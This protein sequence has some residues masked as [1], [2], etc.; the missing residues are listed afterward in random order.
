[1]AVCSPTRAGL[2]TGRYQQRTGVDVVVNADPKVAYYWRGLQPREVTFAEGLKTAGYA[3]AIFGKWHVGYLPK[4]NPLHQGFDRFRGFVSGNID[5]RSHYDR[6]ETFDWW[7][8]LKK[9]DETGYS[10]HLINAH[11]VRFIEENKD[12]PF[13]IYVAH[14][15]IHNPN[16]GPH[17]PPIRGPNKKPSKSLSPLNEAVKAM[18]LAMDEG[19]GQIRAKL[20]ELGLEKNTLVWF[21]SDNGG[22]RQ[23]RS[24]GPR[25]RGRSHSCDRTDRSEHSAHRTA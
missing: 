4:Y 24:T 16:Q 11:A 19:V 10:T 25:L 9:Q 14:E 21:F 5:Y 13:C 8:D 6:M 22:T 12:R 15:A 23:N 2:L 1:M 7:Q 18:T 20:V 17:D 3:T